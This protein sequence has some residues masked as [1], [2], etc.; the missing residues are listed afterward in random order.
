MLWKSCGPAPSPTDAVEVGFLL[1]ALMSY[2]VQQRT[3]EIA[4]RMAL[5]A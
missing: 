5:G 4:I 2:S 3:V 1:Y